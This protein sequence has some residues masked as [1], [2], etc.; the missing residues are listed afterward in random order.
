M[1]NYLNVNKE[2]TD[3][4]LLRLHSNTW[5]HLTVYKQMSPGSFKNVINKM[6]LQIIMTDNG[7]CHKTRPIFRPTFI[8]ITPK[9]TFTG[10]GSTF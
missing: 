10:S 8:A 5:N 9:A 4:K 1:Y 2:M 7:W 3:G 6:C